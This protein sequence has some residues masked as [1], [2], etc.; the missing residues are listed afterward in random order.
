M[1][2]VVVT[3]ELPRHKHLCVELSKTHNVVGIIHPD[4]TAKGKWNSLP[5]LINRFGAYGII[6]A[7]L[8]VLSRLPTRLSGWESGAEGRRV[9]SAFFS[10]SVRDYENLD[11]GVIRRGVNVSSGAALE[12]VVDFAPDVVV[13][14]GGP[15]YPISFIQSAPLMLNY[16][17]G[18]SP[19][20]NGASSMQFAFANG[21]PHLCGG[22][23][24]KI[25]SMVD[26]GD[27][28][29]H[30]LPE[31][32]GTDTPA[33]LSMKSVRAAVLMYDHI[34]RHFEQKGTM[35]F[36]VPQTRP[37]FYYRGIDWT[38]YHAQMVRWHLRRQWAAKFVR[39]ER[40]IEYWNKCDPETA[41]LLC[42]ATISHLLC[43]HL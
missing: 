34:L 26:G 22:T 25:S 38:I 33:T 5:L 2:V 13:C 23:L 7:I 28:L 36:S 19:L 12:L 14:L 9:E 4:V 16:H 40:V 42:E 15:V 30:Y 17:N 20:Y 21:H 29:G 27:I 35:F 3:G 8:H 32:D 37:V 41:K 6:H 24:M 18:L 39:P 1:K 11:H 31:I 10:A 43:N